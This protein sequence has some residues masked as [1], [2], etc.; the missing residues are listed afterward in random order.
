M[1][2]IDAVKNILG[3]TLQLGDRTKQLGAGTPLLGGIPE[4]DSAAVITVILSLEDRFGIIVEDE[5]VSAETFES[6][7]SLAAFIDRKIAE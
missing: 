2:T 4:F 5:E 3:E 7:G 1:A 6:V